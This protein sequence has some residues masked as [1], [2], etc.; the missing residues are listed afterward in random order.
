[1]KK[2]IG[3]VLFLLLMLLMVITSCQKKGDQNKPFI[4][5][6]PPNPQ[7]SVQD[8]PYID[9]GAEA[10]DVTE[11]GDTIQINNRLQT[12]D[13]VN[14]EIAGIYQVYYNVSDEAGNKADQQERE[15]KVLLGK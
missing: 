12:T 3:T 7:Y 1:M 4:I 6:N 15:V 13:N 14:V 2:H 10:F 8:Q 5:M 9:P 11:A